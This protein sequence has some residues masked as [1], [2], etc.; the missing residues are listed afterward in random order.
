[1]NKTKLIFGTMPI[2]NFDDSTYNLIK[3]IKTADLIVIE[4]EKV[5][6]EL[7]KYFNLSITAKIINM[8]TKN[9]LVNGTFINQN[10]YTEN[11]YNIE[12]EILNNI[13]LNKTVLC[14]SD[15]GSAIISDPF[16]IIRRS[17]I[18]KNIKYKVLPGASAIIS[19]LSCSKLYDGG[20]FHFY[21]MLFYNTNKINIYELIKNSPYPSVLFYHLEIQ[22]VFLKE[23]SHF[24]DPNRKIT[25]AGNVTRIDE[26]IIE[27]NIN[28]IM[29][30]V[31]KNEI[32]EA[33]LIISG[34]N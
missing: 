5:I 17:A 27:S 14:L 2:G 9:F 13:N 22:D 8:S 20:P 34:K 11:R 4:N 19:S 7:T 18:E 25:F 1:M 6:K 16:D 21:G 28:D 12:L 26:F 23:L 10:E 30:F 3:Y 32:E 33:T 15:A 29:N 24:I 31:S